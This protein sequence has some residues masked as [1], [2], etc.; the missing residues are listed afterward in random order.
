MT[1]DVENAFLGINGTLFYLFAYL[2]TNLAAFTAVIAFE[3]ATGSTEI[4]D[5]RGLVKRAPV[6][7]GGAVDRPA[8]AGRHAGHGRLPGQVL[9][10]WRGHPVATCPRPL[11]WPWWAS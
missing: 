5:Y 11:P 2:F 8:V 9:C 6:V 1:L 3:S 4:A 10:L 7:A